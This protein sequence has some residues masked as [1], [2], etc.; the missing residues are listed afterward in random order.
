M[1]AG[2]QIA[3]IPP[4]NINPFIYINIYTHIYMFLYF[5]MALFGGGPGFP[6]K[7]Y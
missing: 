4:D 7:K 6:S 1:K 3:K 5:P 2:G